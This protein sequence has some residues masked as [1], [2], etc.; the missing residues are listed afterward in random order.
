MTYRLSSTNNNKNSNKKTPGETVRRGEGVCSPSHM[1][2]VTS[3]VFFVS[4][5]H[6]YTACSRGD[7]R[8]HCLQKGKER[9]DNSPHFKFLVYKC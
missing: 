9:K 6:R 2:I 7:P 3:A 1:H 4:H 5:T 8:E